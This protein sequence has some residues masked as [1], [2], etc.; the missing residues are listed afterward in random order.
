L[1]NAFNYAA[2]QLQK[3][4][5][6]LRQSERE[7]RDVIEAMPT[8]VW[9]AGTDGLNEFGNRRWQEYT[10][11]S[12]ER[13]VGSGWQD[14][15]HPTDLKRHC[16]RWC[17]SLASGEPFENEVRYRR[18]DGQ[19][20]WFLSRAVPLRDEHGKVLKWYGISTD[21]EDR[22]RAEQE[23]EELRADLAHVNRV[24][25]MGEL[26]AS[27][28]HEIKQPIT[29]SVINAETC[30]QWLKQQKPDMEEIRRAATNIVEAG[31]RASGIMDRLRALYKKTPPQRELVDVN[32]VVREMIVLLRGEATRYAVSTRADLAA[33]LPKI[34]ADRVQLQQVLMNLM[35][36]GIEA[37]KDTGGI[38]ALKSEIDQ[39]GQASI[40]VTDTGVGLPT[41]HMDQIFDAFFT[42][43]PAGSGMGLAISRSIIQSHG[44]R[45]WATSNLGRGATF[46]FILPTAAEAIGVPAVGD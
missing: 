28:A 43:K 8:M 27:L 42:T 13:T 11:M 33:D 32:E 7:L 44:G 22:K 16:E 18:A 21:I 26:T 20:R 1:G 45:L 36:N 6:N 34:M 17:A 9:I 2:Q 15:V 19:Y 46:H 12:H 5:D 24:S 10:G 41:D 31:V 40:S 35:L 29:A 3:L 30:L 14:A 4:Y 23:R 37:M 25:T 38:L 39:D